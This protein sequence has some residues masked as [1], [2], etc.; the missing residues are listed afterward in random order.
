MPR[1]PNLKAWRKRHGL[2]Q[3]AAGRALGYQGNTIAKMETGLRGISPRVQ[4]LMR[5]VN[6]FGLI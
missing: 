6:K 2:S 1:K 3:S 5:Y 4:L